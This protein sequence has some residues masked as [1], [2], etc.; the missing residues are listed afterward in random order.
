MFGAKPGKSKPL[1]PTPEAIAQFQEKL[2][3]ERELSAYAPPMSRVKTLANQAL[4]T[5]TG[6]IEAS[7]ISG[8]AVATGPSR[9]APISSTQPSWY[10]MREEMN[11]RA[12]QP[13]AIKLT[14]VE[15]LQRQMENVYPPIVPA[16]T[17]QQ[18]LLRK[19]VDVFENTSSL[20]VAS[21]QATAAVGA[22]AFG[23]MGTALSYVVPKVILDAPRQIIPALQDA[24]ESVGLDLPENFDTTLLD[25]TGA[26]SLLAV[27][28]QPELAGVAIG[29]RRLICVL[30]ALRFN[31]AAAA[32]HLRVVYSILAA[33][34]KPKVGVIAVAGALSGSGSAGSRKLSDPALRPSIAKMEE[35]LHSG[36]S[37]LLKFCGELIQPLPTVS[38]LPASA[39]VAAGNGVQEVPNASSSSIPTM[40]STIPPP[41]PT[42][43][44][45]SVANFKPTSSTSTALVGQ[46]FACD[47]LTM[48]LMP[49]STLDEQLKS[50]H[51]RLIQSVD[52]FL[53]ELG[54]SLGHFDISV[55]YPQFKLFVGLNSLLRDATE[56]DINR[57][58]NRSGSL[59][60]LNALGGVVGARNRVA[61]TLAHI[62]DRL[63]S[64]PHDCIQSPLM[65]LWWL[66]NFQSRQRISSTDLITFVFMEAGGQS[67][68]STDRLVKLEP[69]L[70]NAVAM[71]DKEHDGSISLAEFSRFFYPADRREARFFKVVEVAV[72]CKLASKIKL[73]PALPDH[74]AEIDGVYRIAWN[75][76]QEVAM[77][78]VIHDNLG[79]TKISGAR[80][81]GKSTRVLSVLHC[82]PDERDVAYIDL[83]TCRT[84]E[85]VSAG[86]DF[87]VGSNCFKVLT[88][89]LHSNLTC[90]TDN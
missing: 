12:V 1:K 70:T 23:L 25:S 84:A 66:R 27:E 13:S 71:I 61:A 85:D 65:R 47:P 14:S 4:V 74:I 64:I 68:I 43:P 83:S 57:V 54:L 37:F 41:Q 26:A 44:S 5:P 73:L 79:W 35:S 56:R 60:E 69:D 24:A 36:E 21:G 42:S 72:R 34:A 45:A 88:L 16:L 52:D 67:N 30:K 32:A 33:F 87:F 2:K 50:F 49:E 90:I 6:T 82:M 51:K 86:G 75:N 58:A 20:A 62:R 31:K 10:R 15:D 76:Q 77:G 18:Q 8:L 40:L 11:E 7:P 63:I 38:A 22:E 28:K 3:K 55:A 78:R 81:S 17:Q 48:L 59:E 89:L 19:R 53:V 46:T 80:G 9:S 39:N 29:A